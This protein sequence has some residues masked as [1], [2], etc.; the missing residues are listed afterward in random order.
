MSVYKAVGFIT[1]ISVA[2]NYEIWINNPQ[3]CCAFF[4]KR[5]VLCSNTMPRLQYGEW[6]GHNGIRGNS[7]EK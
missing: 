5:F 4:V 1:L 2:K 7:I 3:S 6:I